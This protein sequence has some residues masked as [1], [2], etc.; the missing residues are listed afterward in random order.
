MRDR[1]HAEAM[2]LWHLLWATLQECSRCSQQNQTRDEGFEF[3]CKA[4]ALAGYSR[5]SETLQLGDSYTG[6]VAYGS[7]PHVLAFTV[8]SAASRKEAT[9]V[10]L[11]LTAIEVSWPSTTSSGCYNV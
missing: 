9:T 1:L 7:N 3:R 8:G 6:D 4:F 2:L 11:G 5:S 10:F